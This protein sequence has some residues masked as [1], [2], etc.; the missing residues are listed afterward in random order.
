MKHKKIIYVVGNSRSG[1][2]M[3][4]RVLNNHSKIYSLP[5]LHF[6]E[7]YNEVDLNIINSESVL[8]NEGLRLNNIIKHGFYHKGLN[9]SDKAE[10]LKHISDSNCKTLINVYDLLV[11]K[12]SNESE[13]ICEQTPQNIF[14]FKEIENHFP[15]SL[16][17]F[18][19]R[20]PRDVMLSQK[21]KW[22][23]AQNG[24]TFIPW[25]ETIRA[26]F[27]YHPFT[28]ARLW[29]SSA[30]VISNANDFQKNSNKLLVRYEDFINDT[31]EIMNQIC[32][33]I[34]IDKEVGM[35]AVNQVGSSDSLDKA[36]KG[37]RKDRVGA[38]KNSSLNSTEIYICELIN[39]KWMKENNY[40]L[41][42]VKPN[43]LLLVIYF[44]IFPFQ[45]T[46][47][48]LMNFKRVKSIGSAIKKRMSL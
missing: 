8:L 3:M 32:S 48:I 42:N 1:T 41:S 11:S 28:I 19:I 7:R 31:D 21:R 5:E 43:Y 6:F 23:R 2:T 44:L 37:I 15:D 35:T 45:I 20:D 46:I 38:W 16:F 25:S 22:R 39:H 40:I 12:S 33:F 18:M 13:I 14:Y 17:I 24:A 29:K 30:M 34:K 47:N 36:T 4:S 27:N 9:E 26:R 10:L